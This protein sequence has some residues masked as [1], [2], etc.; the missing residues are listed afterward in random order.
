MYQLNKRVNLIICQ[1]SKIDDWANHIFDTYDCYKVYDL[2]DASELS[3]F[4]LYS[5][6]AYYV[7]NH[8][9]NYKIVGIIN[10][11]L[12]FRRSCLL[13]LSE[14]TL[15]LDESSLIQNENAKRSKFVLKLGERAASVILLSGTATDGKYERLWSQCRLLGWNI[16]KK[17]FWSQYI[18]WEYLKGSDIPIKIINGYKNVERLKTKLKEHGAQFLKTD[19]V[20]SLPEQIHQTICI[21]TSTEYRQFNKNAIVEIG[22]Q[23]FIG[24]TPLVKLIYKRQL[25]GSYNKFKLAAF[26]DLLES[27]NDRLIVFYNF[28]RELEEMLKIAFELERPVSFIYGAE[29]NLSNYNK[30]DNSI[31]FIQYQAGAMGLNLQ[32]AN[33]IIYFT[34]PVKSELF[35]QS[36]KRTHRIGQQRACFYYY[37][38]CKK[39]VEEEIY[40]TLKMRKDFTDELFRESEGIHGC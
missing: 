25:C 5:D 1:K 19:D 11:E 34:P 30:H 7:E 3:T 20:L 40:S 21:P 26:K 15:I 27:T 12:A 6:D 10:Y 39:S 9:D 14:F 28:T 4:M 16:S 32:K 33:K 13:E 17:L 37:L 18:D 22:E 29:K 38:T 23:T 8:G 24:D 36:K 2:T 35:E 31:T